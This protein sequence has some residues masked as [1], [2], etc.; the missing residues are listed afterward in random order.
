MQSITNE[1]DN[2]LQNNYFQKNID[3]FAAI[4]GE[5]V[6]KQSAPTEKQ[7]TILSEAY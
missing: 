6:Y 3:Y 1:K 2:S 7:L 5:E 4:L